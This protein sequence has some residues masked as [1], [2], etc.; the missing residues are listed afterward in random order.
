MKEK[1]I[2]A[3]INAYRNHLFKHNGSLSLM[4]I[5]EF[6]SWK[7]SDIPEDVLN[8]HLELKKYIGLIENKFNLFNEIKEIEKRAKEIYFVFQPVPW[9]EI[10]EN[11][12]KYL[13]LEDLQRYEEI[14]KELS[15]K[16]NIYESNIY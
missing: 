14:K 12:D 3:R 5:R 7:E 4:D 10:I 9:K 11:R 8:E 16:Y 6:N 13:E 15:E 1:K 2:R